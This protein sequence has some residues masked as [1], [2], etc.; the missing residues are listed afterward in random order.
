MTSHIA[1]YLALIMCQTLGI[2]LFTPQKKKK[3][4]IGNIIP[5]P[6]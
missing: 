3:I 2:V 1:I 4:K 5:L 6:K